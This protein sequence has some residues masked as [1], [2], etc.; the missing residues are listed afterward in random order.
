MISRMGL[1]HMNY[2]RLTEDVRSSRCSVTSAL[3]AK[4]GANNRA[5]VADR[6]LGWKISKQAAYIYI[7]GGNI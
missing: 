6:G 5:A 2:D 7:L 4:F 1:M 3:R